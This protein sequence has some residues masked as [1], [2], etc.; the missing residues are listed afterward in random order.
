MYN[1]DLRIIRLRD[2]LN[3]LT[4]VKCSKIENIQIRRGRI[5]FPCDFSG[6]SDGFVP[7][8]QGE[9]WS[10][11]AFD[12]YATF[13]FS[14]DV[15]KADVGYEYALSV[16]TNKYDGH[17][18]QRPQMLLLVGNEPLCGLDSNHQRV[19]LGS[20]AGEG[21]KEINIYAFSGISKPGPYGRY[22]EMDNH[23]GVRLY[24]ELQLID[25]RV[26]EYYY[27]LAVP[28]MYLSF[29]DK[30]SGEYSKILGALN[31]SLNFLDLR[32]P[33]SEEFYKGIEQANNY[34]KNN[35]YGYTAPECGKATLVGHTHIDIAWLWTYSHTRNK[36]VRSF[37]TEAKL[38]SEYPEHRFMSSQAALYNY[39]KEDNPEL[40]EKI[41]RLIKEGKWEAEGAMWVEPDMN[42]SSGE[43]IVRQIM[44]GKRFFKEEFG[45][46]SEIL[47]LPDVFGYSAALPQI[48]K[49]SDLK[50]FMT[51]KLPSNEL[52]RFP[53]DTFVWRG[54]D[55]SEILS[56]CTNYV[57]GYNA[58]IESGEIYTG[59]QKYKQ[60]D[61]N[62]DILINFGYADGGGGVTPEQI[63]TVKRTNVGIP[64]VPKTEIG[65]PLDYFKRLDKKVLGNRKLPI[66]SGEIYYERH[67]GT[68]TSMARVKKQN[69]KCEFLLSNA[70]WL[71]SLSA[72]LGGVRL[73]R[74]RFE[75]AMKNMLLNQFHDVLPG[76][77][78]EEVY[79]D[80]DNLYEE[81]FTIGNDICQK[82]IF[83][84]LSPCEKT[85]T[86]FNPYSKKM[87]GYV[88]YNGRYLFVSDIPAKGY[89]TRS[90]DSSTP[91]VSVR[92]EGNVVE[93]KYYTITLSERGEISSLYDKISK[94][95]V[96]AFGKTA[97]KLRIF[98]DLP[99]LEG[100]V[101]E[102]NWNLDPYYTEREFEL[103]APEKVEIVDKCDEYAILRTKRNYMS[104]SIIID[105]I[106]YARSPRIDFKARID[107]KEKHQLIKVE[108]PVNVNATRSAYEI[109][110]G[111]VERNTTFNNSFDE[112]RYE[113]CG[114]KWA[115]V[116][117]NGYG[118]SLLNDCKYGYSAKG[119]DISLTLLR[120]GCCPNPLADKEVHEFTYSILPHN[121]SFVEA[122]V[123]KEAYSLN[124]PMFAVCGD[125]VS[126]GMPA[127]F[128]FVECDGA[129]VDTIKPAESDDGTVLRIYEPYNKSE[130]VILRFGFE[131]KE[132]VF[133]TLTEERI[134]EGQKYEIS[135]GNTLAFDIKPFEIVTLKIKPK[136]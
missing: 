15:P 51:C 39:V 55:G 58:Q 56:H 9:E 61:I 82:A 111:F 88:E 118:L 12:S 59:W 97:N 120:S 8:T 53:Y 131:I 65:T 95:E 34:L 73:P 4:N 93:N 123:V 18:M 115:D 40:Y 47:W 109:Q 74:D 10:D 117:D 135:G 60:K 136:I 41:K 48:L 119:S 99:G 94:R 91:D 20:I 127:E 54:I 83:S 31:D 14:L 32:V 7:Y 125:A 6:I 33:Y 63:E 42:L 86:V 27:N 76:T 11:T 85:I 133:T 102:D 70:E 72:H 107:W 78:I 25:K 50:Y 77:S 19:A 71:S 106:V 35:L 57:C 129:V 130:K 5:D 100:G 84:F 21:N 110:Y 1:L 38:L 69:R 44:Y 67:R 81:A 124:N 29:M 98:E 36:A 104:S 79:R 52:N 62:D 46:D 121:G 112:A 45:V 128:S 87:S 75:L 96:V 122:D 113:V 116:S 2:E 26:E 92:V 37:A 105:M 132:V 13:R 23:D 90:L 43:S 64:G 89:A 28:F 108:F 24:A 3:S 134:I 126:C 103:S 114:H 80:S 22:V 17:N 101:L 16:T 68:Y 30:A 49:K 66:Y